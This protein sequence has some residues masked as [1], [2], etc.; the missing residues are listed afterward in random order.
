MT[1]LSASRRGSSAPATQSLSSL[2]GDDVLFLSS[3]DWVAGLSLGSPYANPIPLS[4]APS[5]PQSTS[6]LTPLT[7]HS[8]SSQLHMF[9]DMPVPT[10]EHGHYLAVNSQLPW[11]SDSLLVPPLHHDVSSQGSSPE[12][13]LP[14][15]SPSFLDA[16]G[17]AETPSAAATEEPKKPKRSR[18]N[19]YKNAPPAV[20][21]RRRAANRKSQ[22]AYR[23][24][25]D[26]RIAE[27]EELL[28]QANKR[29]QEMG[30]AYMTLRAEYEQLL[31]IGSPDSSSNNNHHHGR[32]PS[33]A[34]TSCTA[35]SASAAA[36]TAT[37]TAE[38]E[39]AASTFLALAAFA[40]PNVDGSHGLSPQLAHN[41][42]HP[43]QPASSPH[44]LSVYPPP[45]M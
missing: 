12:A 15:E 30:R 18:P 24:R 19:R 16:D 1:K 4:L 25:K 9:P 20:I 33:I 45:P 14:S 23:K 26:D 42:Q 13:R 27:L 11:S 40:H 10:F 39:E 34:S 36:A 35:A 38:E 8:Q 17:D 28:S 29:E 21:Q 32:S 31:V 22:R 7:P 37:A 3:A 6:Q 2:P 5:P 44:L 43:Q 41:P